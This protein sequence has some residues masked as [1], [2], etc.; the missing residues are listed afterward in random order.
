VPDL[1]QLWIFWVT[2]AMLVAAGIG[3]PI[4]EELP[5][6]GAG[7]WAANNAEIGPIRWLILPVCILGIVISDVLLYAIGRYGGARLLQF[8]WVARLMPPDKREKIEANFA[9]YG[10]KVLLVIRWLPG[11]RSPMFITAGM[12][13]V[14]LWRFVIADA[15]AA[16]LGHTLL[17]FLAYWFGDQFRDLVV[18]AEQEVD[19]LRPILV[20]SA[21]AAV[22][23]FF[24]Y[25]YTRRPVTTA[26]PKE[27][28]LIGEKVAAGIESLESGTFL[29]RAHETTDR[30]PHLAAEEAAVNHVEKVKEETRNVQPPVSP[31]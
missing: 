31:S 6:I 19:K 27:L 29:G 15:V 10:L 9:H 3:V 21:I 11:I 13:R 24:L 28:P 2:F 16:S 1:S 17:F 30:K 8:R 4:P 5:V 20:I 7:I 12:M 18:H 22:A 23:L 26:D 14:P 25:R